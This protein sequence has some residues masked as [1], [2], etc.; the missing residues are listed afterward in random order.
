MF[1]HNK[2]LHRLALEIEGLTK[3]YEQTLFKQFD[4]MVQVGE[5]IAIIGPNG[6]GKTTLLKCMAGETKQ[7]LLIAFSQTFYFQCQP[8]QFLI[9]FEA[10]KRV[11]S[12]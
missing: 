9:L 8:M 2:K 1:A 6:I 11:F 10:D 3:S 5:R 12:A 4:L 7:C